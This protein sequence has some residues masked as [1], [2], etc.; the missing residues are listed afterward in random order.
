METLGK[1]FDAMWFGISRFPGRHLGRGLEVRL[2][3]STTRIESVRTASCG[4]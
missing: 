3:V 1:D 4:L 2:L